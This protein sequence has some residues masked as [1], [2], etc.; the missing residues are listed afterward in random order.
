MLQQTQVATVVPYFSRFVEQFPDAHTLAQ[1]PLEQV[2][3]AW[4]GLGYYR[5]ARQLHQAA[6][7]IV[8]DHGGEFPQD[9]DAVRRL[10][11]IGRYTAGAVLSIALNQRHPV[12][13]ANTIRVL[14]RLFAVAIDVGKE[15]G[16]RTLWS[17]A[18]QLVPAARPGDFNQALME[19]GGTIC[20]RRDPNCENCPISRWCR[21]AQLRQVERFPRKSPRAK[22]TFQQ[23]VAVVVQRQR[24]VVLRRCGPDERWA[25]MW[26]FPRYRR[27]ER[28]VE[29]A[30]AEMIRADL[31]LSVQLHSLPWRFKYSVTRYRIDLTTV[32]STRCRGRIKTSSPAKWVKIEEMETF[33]LNVSARRVARQLRLSQRKLN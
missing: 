2:L 33:P 23:E 4:E 20:K 27:P 8:R 15:S 6:Q 24:S 32:A 30:L 14:S 12:V 10:P 22:V 9:I 21:A 28:N 16:R 11:G 25:G 18:E 7:M 29:S 13:E 1:A 5:R 19:L 3:R 31:G 17:L 26:D